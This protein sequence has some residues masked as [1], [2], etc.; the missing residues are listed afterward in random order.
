MLHW[1]RIEALPIDAGDEPL[2][3]RLSQGEQP[4]AGAGP[5]EMALMQT[6]L[7]QPHT[8]AVPLQQ[9]E[10]RAAPITKSIGRTVA[11][12]TS[13][14]LLNVRRKPVDPQ[15]HI[16]RL[17][18]QPN[19]C[20][21]Q[22]QTIPRS[23]PASQTASTPAGNVICQPLACCNSNSPLTDGPCTASGT[24]V[25]GLGL[26]AAPDPVGQRLGFEFMLMAVGDLRQP[27]VP[28]GLNMPS[29]GLAPRVHRFH[30]NPLLKNA[31]DAG[32]GCSS[33]RWAG[34]T[35]TVEHPFRVIK[36]QFGYTKV[37]FRGLVKN[38]AQQVTLFALS[39]LWMVRKQLMIAGEVRP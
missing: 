29:P 39:N 18:H 28:P 14:R 10:P 37:R 32:R 24:R 5:A 23:N 13:E 26:L 19:L 7:A 38:T 12:L 33:K 22:H 30:V 9:L 16:D 21:R 25:S 35:L 11:R 8:G 36:R 27:A 15:A 4:V 17:D 6:P 1:Q 3:L 20:G 34:W 31:E 2:P